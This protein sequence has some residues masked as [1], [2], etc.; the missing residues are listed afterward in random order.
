MRLLFANTNKTARAAARTPAGTRDRRNAAASPPRNSLQ[1]ELPLPQLIR[2]L[3]AVFQH[4][5]LPAPQTEA[6]WLLAGLLNLKRSD[7]Y[8]DYD[9]R[10]TAVQQQTAWEYVHRRLQ[11]E[12]LQYILRASEFYGLE[13]E[14][15]PAVL[16]PRPETELLVEKVIALARQQPGAHL[17]DLGTGAGCIAVTLA[18]HL[19]QARLVA[20]DSS[21]AALATARTNAQR[22]HVVERIEFRLADMCAARAFASA[23]QFDFVVSN[24]PYVLWQEREELPPEIREYEPAAA[25]FVEEGLQYYRC[26]LA[27]CQ[28]HLKAGGW[29]ACEMASQRH[30]QIES[31]FREGNFA[32]SEILMDYA[33]HPRHLIAQ[34]QNGG[35]R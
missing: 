6:E 29:L 32:K 19:P 34:A 33:G 9:R 1:T 20:V 14:V 18:K 30:A 10:L 11:H 16:I 31:L 5:G 28:S 26:L 21:A 7:L 23:E 35:S 2:H 4:E 3:T 22:H 13:F 12:P 24:P 8:R 17:I 15:N 27:F 25:L